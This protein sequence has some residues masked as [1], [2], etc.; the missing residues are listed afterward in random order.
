VPTLA[1]VLK[2]ALKGERPYPYGAAND[3]VKALAAKP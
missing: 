2:Q 1:R 3:V